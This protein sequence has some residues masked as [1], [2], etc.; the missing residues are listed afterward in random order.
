M[1]RRTCALYKDKIYSWIDL[2]RKFK[3]KHQKGVSA[4]IE[5]ENAYSK[6]RKPPEIETIYWDEISKNNERK[7]FKLPKNNL[8]KRHY[9][10]VWNRDIGNSKSGK[11][12][13]CRRVVTDDN[14]ECGHIISVSNNGS[15]HV[16]NLRAVCLPCN[17]AM[18]T[19]NLEDFKKDFDIEIFNK[20]LTLIKVTKE[21]VIK[22]LTTHKSNDVNIKFFNKAIELLENCQE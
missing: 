10:F 17:R 3:I 6:M 19:Q 4:H 7:T 16:N 11:C 22:F 14:F 8:T 15:N 20:E 1:G 13:V 12:Y 5:W 9:Q 2:L 21:D 18:G